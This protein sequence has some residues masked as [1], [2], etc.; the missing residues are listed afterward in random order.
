MYVMKWQHIHY[1]VIMLPLPHLTQSLELSVDCSML[2]DNTFW[3]ACGTTC[4]NN[5]S[6]I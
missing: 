2:V 6:V 3:L 1:S 4:I 5:Q